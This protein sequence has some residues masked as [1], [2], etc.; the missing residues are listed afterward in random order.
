MLIAV[1]EKTG[2]KSIKRIILKMVAWKEGA[3]KA[4]GCEKNVVKAL[5]SRQMVE[6]LSETKKQNVSVII[7][8]PIKI[9]PMYVSCP[10]VM[11]ALHQR[12]L[13]STNWKL[14]NKLFNKSIL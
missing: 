4:E 11:H 10:K 12:P 8:H 5:K 6:R 13:S 1:L 7:H 3:E 9:R 2:E 14:T